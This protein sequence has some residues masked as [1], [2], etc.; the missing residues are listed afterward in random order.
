MVLLGVTIFFDAE[1]ISLSPFPVSRTTQV[2]FESRFCFCFINPAYAAAA[3]GSEKSPQLED[4]SFCAERIS[5]SVN[6]MQ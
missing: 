5:S 4:N 1:F 2:E 6:V 3:A